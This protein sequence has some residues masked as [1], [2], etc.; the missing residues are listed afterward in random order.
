MQ[1]SMPTLRVEAVADQ[2]FVLYVTVSNILIFQV[3]A[4]S[5]VAL[6]PFEEFQVNGHPQVAPEMTRSFGPPSLIDIE[7]RL[8]EWLQKSKKWC[9]RDGKLLI[10][11][12]TVELE[13]EYEGP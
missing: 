8:I 1:Q 2:Q 11:G 5:T 10:Q 13:F 12:A 4:W 3:R 6:A 9:S 7:Q